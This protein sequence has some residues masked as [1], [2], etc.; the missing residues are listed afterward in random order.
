VP[1]GIS[2]SHSEFI[3][4]SIDENVMRIGL[5]RLEKKNALTQ[6]MYEAIA[7]ALVDADSRK[8]VRVVV[9]HGHPSCF[10][11]GN[12]LADFNARDPNELSNAIK[13]LLVMHE[14]QKPL[15][16]AVSGIAVGIGTTMLLHCDIV[17][18]AQD[19]RFRLPF[20]NLGLC[21]E[22]ASSLLLPMKAG[23][24]LASELLLFGE[25]FDCDTAIRSGLVN[26]S[27][28]SERLLEF[29]LERA[30]QLTAQP[31]QA[32]LESK[33][34]MKAHNHDVI[35]NCLLNE[36][37]VFSQLL[38]SEESIQARDQALGSKGSGV[39]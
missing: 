25:F 3:D 18:A 19:T 17:Y 35:K 22:A 1:G 34:L 21:P 14:M 29:T 28:A 37:K 33:R 24:R 13:L 39:R 16:A 15:M 10:T 4:V 31:L 6:P 23:H 38:E 12:D 36:A 30:Q 32:I 8:D 26:S 20:A 9:L 11:A 2:L 5:N 7:T 27:Q